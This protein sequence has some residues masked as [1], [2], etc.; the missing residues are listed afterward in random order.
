MK[1]YLLHLEYM[2]MVM[3]KSV[4]DTCVHSLYHNHYSTYVFPT[5]CLHAWFLLITWMPACMLNIIRWSMRCVAAR[6]SEEYAF[7]PFD[8]SPPSLRRPTMTTCAAVCSR[9]SVFCGQKKMPTSVHRFC[10]DRRRRRRRRRLICISAAS[11]LTSLAS[12]S[13]IRHDQA[14]SATPGVWRF[15]Q[16]HVCSRIGY[17]WEMCLTHRGN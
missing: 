15:A 12:Q 13:W 7:H 2:V 4:A 9:F 8:T 6:R 11:A 5:A 10:S 16:L 14:K 1:F 3:E 17:I